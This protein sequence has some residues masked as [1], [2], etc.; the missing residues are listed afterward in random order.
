MKSH[1]KRICLS[2]KQCTQGVPVLCVGCNFLFLFFVFVLVTLPSFIVAL[3]LAVNR[4]EYCRS[5]RQKTFL[6]WGVSTWRI[7]F[8]K[9]QTYF[10][11]TI[12][13]QELYKPP[14]TAKGL[15]IENVMNAIQCTAE[16]A[17]HTGLQY[18]VKGNTYILW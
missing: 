16:R 10:K 9:S 8:F 12:V 1:Y 15:I 4:V 18:H 6:K 17:S 7:F 14:T 5:C 13:C 2:R 11:G 3:I